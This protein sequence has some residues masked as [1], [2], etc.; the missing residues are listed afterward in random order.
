MKNYTVFKVL[1]ALFLAS[2]VGAQ[3]P[4]WP[5]PAPSAATCG[6]V[7]SIN[8]VIG[9]P[10]ITLWNGGGTHRVRQTIR[11]LQGCTLKIENVTLDFV[12]G[13]G[14]TVE[15]G[16]VL[17]IDNATLTNSCV[18]SAT[19]PE[20]HRWA[21][22]KVKGT[23]NVANS[24]IGAHGKVIIADSEIRHAD[25]AIEQLGGCLGTGGGIIQVTDV[26]FVNNIKGIIFS[27]HHAQNESKI[28]GCTFLVD[29]EFMNFNLTSPLPSPSTT[30]EW[31]LRSEFDER[32]VAQVILD[33]NDGVV[34]QGCQF[35]NYFSADEGIWANPTG[36]LQVFAT[37]SAAPTWVTSPPDVKL[38]AHPRWQGS[39]IW[40]SNSEI[41]VEGAGGVA[42]AD[43]TNTNRN[44]FIGWYYGIHA[45][46]TL[47]DDDELIVKNS[48]FRDNKYGLYTQNMG[49]V[50]IVDN[51]FRETND[52][53]KRFRFLNADGDDFN[54]TFNVY[55][56]HIVHEVHELYVQNNV[57]DVDVLVNF[58]AYSGLSY[59]L[60]NNHFPDIVKIQGNSFT[61]TVHTHVT[62]ACPTPP[63]PPTPECGLDQED[64]GPQHKI[65]L[66]GVYFSNVGASTGSAKKFYMDCNTFDFSNGA[67]YRTST[68]YRRDM[69][70]HE[71]ANLPPGLQITVESELNPGSTPQNTW[72]D[73]STNCNAAFVNYAAFNIESEFDINYPSFQTSSGPP[74]IGEPTC[75]TTATVLPIANTPAPTNS[76]LSCG[77]YTTEDPGQFPPMGNNESFEN[78]SLEV[79][80]NPATEI[81]GVQSIENGPYK[82]LS[83]DGRTVLS[84]TQL[85]EGK[86]EIDISSLP[87]GEYIIHFTGNSSTETVKF[88][89][90]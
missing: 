31:S 39:G 11:V 82:I 19:V 60:A 29:D 61:G 50:E 57:F 3:T 44:V 83:I 48:V 4:T 86:N 18:A 35:L 62:P 75:V 45:I 7:S 30:R 2:G 59:Q 53:F 8:Y 58:A 56:V 9:T 26:Q 67:P 20:Q 84:G 16:G 12:T 77:A 37:P 88:M 25:V 22:I 36:T 65:N 78:G 79:F 80:P 34:I 43:E 10:G 27:E 54:P 52:I 87:N 73:Y 32:P 28:V 38:W 70:F 81:L 24:V 21:G 15:V 46:N 23:T 14:I 5:F 72:T 76:C 49:K 33:E 55:G 66:R 47:F 89:K 41:T 85:V 74:S 17:D 90:E 69:I 51:I 68:N 6:Q 1:M 42:C 13:T 40:A 64:P 63:T 71:G